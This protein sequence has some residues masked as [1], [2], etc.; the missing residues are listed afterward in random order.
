MLTV[1]MGKRA[2]FDRRTEA[3]EFETWRLK[4]GPESLE[5]ALS[6]DRKTPFP[7]SR[8]CKFA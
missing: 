2:I 7:L 3:V 5:W 8:D 4:E 6:I 1:L